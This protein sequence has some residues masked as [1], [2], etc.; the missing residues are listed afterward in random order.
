M[1][2]ARYAARWS[3]GTGS[4]PDTV[5]IELDQEDIA[6]EQFDPSAYLR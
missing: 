5:N 4:A 1:P 6:D 2:H 3:L